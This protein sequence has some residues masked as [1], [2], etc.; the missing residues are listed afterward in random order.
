MTARHRDLIRAYQQTLAAAADERSRQ[1]WEKYLKGAIPFRGV[2]IPR[3][4]ELLADWR[5]RHGIDDWAAAAQFELALDLLREPIA[6]DKLAGILSIQLHLV[7]AIPWQTALA[8]YREVFDESQIFDWNTCDWFCVRVLGPTVE[9]NGED[10]AAA[11]AGWRDAASL[12]RARA[13]VVAFVNLAAQPALRAHALAACATL[14]GREERFAKTA[15]GWFLRDLSRHDRQAVL[16]FVERHLPSFSRE[17]LA[18]ALKY[19]D[20]GE[21][22]SWLQRLRQAG[23][24]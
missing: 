7:D 23:P 2:G 4:R 14:V 21:Q 13:S 15:V 12:W 6:E 9:A 22:K 3:N 24:G 17:S 19:F 18:N 5:R 16:A 8:R 1:W 20:K 11:V 10:C